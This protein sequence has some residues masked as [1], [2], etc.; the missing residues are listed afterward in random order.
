MGREFGDRLGF[1]LAPNRTVENF[2]LYYMKGISTVNFME[3]I[4][5]PL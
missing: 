4:Y 2:Q 1:Y 3:I 5:T